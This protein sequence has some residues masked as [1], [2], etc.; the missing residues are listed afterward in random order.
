MYCWRSPGMKSH[1][2]DEEEREESKEKYE[3]IKGGERDLTY[4]RKYFHFIST[5][6]K[7]GSKSVLH[8]SQLNCGPTQ[9][10]RAIKLPTPLL[11]GSGVGQ[12]RL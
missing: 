8:N 11:D 3:K 12:C 10:S 4:D 7:P 1:E 9:F 2:L 5:L 6:N